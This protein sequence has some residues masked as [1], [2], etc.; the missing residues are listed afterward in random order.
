[1]NNE[2]GRKITSLTLM[3]IM[4]AGGIT[5]SGASFAMAPYMPEAI[6]DHSGTDGTLSVSSTHVMGGGIVGI[7]ID[8]PAIGAT[9]QQIAPPSV[10]FAGTAVDMTQMTDGT[11]VAYVVDHESA[12]SIMTSDLGSATTSRGGM[13]ID[14]GILCDGGIGVNNVSASNLETTSGEGNTD[15]EVTSTSSYFQGVIKQHMD[16]TCT[17]ANDAQTK[18]GGRVMINV[19]MDPPTVNSNSGTGTNNTGNRNIVLNATTPG[20][21][22]WPFIQAINFSSTNAVTS[23]DEEVSVEV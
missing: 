23:G 16:W 20:L 15:T 7:T 13:S 6:A 5:I 3:T 9:D 12:K 11:W 14:Y 18:G 4:F 21:G 1:M 19:L 2:L 22:A 17:E 8:D 10:D